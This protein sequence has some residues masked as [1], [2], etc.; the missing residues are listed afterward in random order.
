MINGAWYPLYSQNKEEGQN[1][2]GHISN[3]IH[4]VI[5]YVA[6][7]CINCSDKPIKLIVHG[8]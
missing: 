6:Y 2:I 3:L 5:T 8:L 7:E 4:N 1:N